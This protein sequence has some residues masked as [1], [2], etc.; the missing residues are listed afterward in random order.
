MR[1]DILGSEMISQ[2]KHWWLYVLKL[3][4]NKWYVGISTNVDKRFHQHK[5]GFAGAAWTK[6]YKPI[7]LHDK[8]DLGFC[9]IERAQ[10][11]EGRVTRRY[12]EEYGDNNVRGGDL[13]DVG[14]Y[15]R[16]F[17]RFFL[18]EQWSTLLVI[19]FEL[20]VILYLAIDKYF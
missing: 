1:F 20:F 19:V 15:T 2:N 17:G 4:D 16:H 6:K 5:K 7:A 8:Q 9:E 11:Y 3:E 12:M 10:L 14:D 13:T 18:A